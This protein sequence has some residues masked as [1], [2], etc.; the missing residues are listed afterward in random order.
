VETVL[1]G[2]NWGATVMG[3][4]GRESEGL[5]RM[6]TALMPVEEV[7]AGMA[8]QAACTVAVVETAL[9]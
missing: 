8:H 2:H 6:E 5:V 9:K 7:S 3:G 1:G 4:K